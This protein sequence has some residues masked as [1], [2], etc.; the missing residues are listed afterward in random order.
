MTNPWSRGT[1]K[2]RKKEE[3]QIRKWAND[4]KIMSTKD[5]VMLKKKHKMYIGEQSIYTICR[6]IMAKRR[7]KDIR[8]CSTNNKMLGLVET[9]PPEIEAAKSRYTPAEWKVILK[10][11]A[12]GKMRYA[13][14]T[15]EPPII[16]FSG[17]WFRFGL[18][19][20]THWGSIYMDEKVW[21]AAVK[22]MKDEGC[23]LLIHAGD[24]FEGT[25][26][27]RPGHF[28]EL[29]H[30]GYDAQMAHGTAQ[31]EKWEKDKYLLSGNHDE[32]A[33]QD[34]GADMVRALCGKFNNA[35]YLGMIEGEMT[36]KNIPVMIFHGG[37]GK[38]YAKTYS[39]QQKIGSITAA[40]PKVYIEGHTHKAFYTPF[41]H[42]H[43]IG[44]GCLQY[45]SGFMKKHNMAADV[46]YWIVDIKIN[47][48]GTA[49]I[50]PMWN[51]FYK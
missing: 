51:P 38:A 18:V 50:R 40:K 36:I 32:W 17:E 15:Q 14:G 13:P 24:Y 20:D 25:L 41:R 10:S 48:Q 2:Q 46:G 44:G 5:I 6:P 3:E 35:Y 16:D 27:R 29:S 12:T 45:Q 34:A 42:V 1:E 4:P 7:E 19:S 21:D 23:E 22:D 37:S 49:K 33:Q 26:T 31:M 39:A 43:A 47:K 11:L 28:Y 30:V 8:V 9:L